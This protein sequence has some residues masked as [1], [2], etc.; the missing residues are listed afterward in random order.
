M[1]TR[2]MGMLGDWTSTVGFKAVGI[3]VYAVSPED[4]L[5]VWK[6]LAME[7][8]A[9]V[10]MTEPV[11]EALRGHI[12]DFPAHEGL[13]VVL[14]IPPVTGSTGIAGR[15]IRERVIKALGSVVQG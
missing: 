2:K 3:Q 7:E 1:E 11:F 4:A 13:P 5:E 15:I 6:N 9:M 10:L 14:A 8:L 12:P